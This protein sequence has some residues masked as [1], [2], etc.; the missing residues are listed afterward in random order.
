MMFCL[1]LFTFDYEIIPNAISLGQVL[2]LPLTGIILTI[3]QYVLKGLLF[4]FRRDAA[5]L[6]VH[7]YF[8]L[9]V[10]NSPNCSF[11]APVIISLDTSLG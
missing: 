3:L 2:S 8:S 7:N 6:T 9:L 11:F 1:K 5:A 10:I 4:F